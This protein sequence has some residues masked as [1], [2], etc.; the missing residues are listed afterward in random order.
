MPEVTGGRGALL[1]LLISPWVNKMSPL[2]FLALFYLLRVMQGIPS[3]LKKQIVQK[4]DLLF[5]NYLYKLGIEL[6]VE[7]YL[8]RSKYYGLF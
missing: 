2:P 6:F 7:F 3:M 5:L 8:I 4:I 1:L